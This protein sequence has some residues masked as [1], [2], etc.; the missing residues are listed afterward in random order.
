MTPAEYVQLKAFARLDG[1]RLAL[2]WVACFACYIV[3]IANPLYSMVAIVLMIA[4]PFFVSRRLAKFR[5]EGLGGVISFGRGWGYSLYVFLYASI[6]LALAQYVYF[7][8]IDQGYLLKSF[9][10]ALS[11]SEARQVVEQYGAQQMIQESMEQFSQMRPI[12]YALNILT[13]NIVIGAVL[14]LPIAALIKKIK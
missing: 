12:D 7:A 2:L 1:A 6:L 3:G 9:T 5:D 14:G 10:E 4:T 8:F 13:V 11:S